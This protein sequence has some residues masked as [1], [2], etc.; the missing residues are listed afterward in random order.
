MNTINGILV[1]AVTL[2]APQFVQAQGTT[3]V[4]SLGETT[5]GSLSVG[6]DSWLAIFFSTGGF[7][8]KYSLNSVQLNMADATGNPNAFTVTLYSAINTHGAIFPDTSL[9]TLNGS[10]SPVSNGIYT[11]TAAS[12]IDLFQNSAYFIVLTSGTTVANGAYDLNITSTYPPS[13]GGGWGGDLLSSHS[14]DGVNWNYI[15]GNHALFAIT[16]TPIPEPPAEVLLGLG[17]ILLL[18]FGRWKA[19]TA[20]EKLIV[21]AI[22]ICAITLLVPHIIQAQGSTCWDAYSAHDL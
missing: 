11:Y 9:G 13:T 14:S 7:Q 20:N 3:Y 17:G 2:S 18:G 1:L 21:N 22:S 4:S 16:A 8:A 10:L 5:V 19:K 12:S 6:S 15:G